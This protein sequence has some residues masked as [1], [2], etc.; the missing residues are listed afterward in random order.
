MADLF[1][2]QKKCLPCRCILH[3]RSDKKFCNLKC[4]NAYNNARH[5][6]RKNIFSH[7][8]DQMHKNWDVLHKYFEDSK[9]ERFLKIIPLYRQGF[10][11]KFYCGTLIVTE[12]GET[13]YIIY[14]YAFT[15]DKSE[16]IK[17]FYKDGGFH[18]I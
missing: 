4:K 9:G 2:N 6:K 16:Q 11:P 1:E 8:D 3:G 13:V 12:T 14:N 18:N 7:D 5:R 15:L 10:N 17:I